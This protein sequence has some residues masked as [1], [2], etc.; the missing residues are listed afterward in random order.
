MIDDPA[1]KVLM[2]NA[3]AMKRGALPLWTIYE[4]PL[5]HPDGFLARRFE[6]SAKDGAV[7]TMDTV[8][9][10]LEEIR[11]IFWKAGLMKLS[12]SPGDEPQ[13]VETWV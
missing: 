4:R 11:Q 6:S 5:D 10:E 3:E 1:F 2:A 13:I 9:G 12:R 7:A 8:K